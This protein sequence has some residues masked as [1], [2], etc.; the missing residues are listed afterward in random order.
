MRNTI[1]NKIIYETVCNMYTH[2]SA[3]DIYEEVIK[4][5]PTVSKGT[6]YRNLNQLASDGKILRIEVANA[7]DRFDHTITPHVHIKCNEC[8]RV[9]DIPFDNQPV[10]S[11][12]NDENFK[13]TGYN[14]MFYGYCKE[15]MN[16]KEE[17]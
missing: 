4:K 8:G 13:I 15:C 5:W 1:Q 2:P 3:D 12:N 14:L 7:P 6:V 9:F 11:Y 17:I 16:S 10:L